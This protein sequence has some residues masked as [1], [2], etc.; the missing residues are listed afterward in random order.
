MDL[1]VPHRCC[2]YSTR[3]WRPIPGRARAPPAWAPP[4]SLRPSRLL[5]RSWL[6]DG[7][8]RGVEDLLLLRCLPKGSSL[9]A[10]RAPPR[11]SASAMASCRCALPSLVLRLL[12]RTWLIDGV[13]GLPPS[14][15]PL[16]LAICFGMP[17]R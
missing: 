14:S 7:A 9:S 16:P 10:R 13:V 6:I 4:A 8:A 1:R 2:Y 17:L 15:S 5:R 12:R 3:L 11:A